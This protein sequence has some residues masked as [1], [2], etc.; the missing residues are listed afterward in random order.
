[1]SDSSQRV[2]TPTPYAFIASKHTGVIALSIEK[3]ADKYYFDPYDPYHK[4]AYLSWAYLIRKSVCDELDIETN[5]FDVGYR[6]SPTTKLPE[7][8][9]VERADNGAGYC[10]YLNGKTDRE[11]SKKVFIDS[12]KPGE[13][14]VYANVLMLPDHEQHCSSSCYDC[15]LDYYNQQHHGSLNWRIALDLVALSDNPNAE[16]DFSQPYWNTYIHETLLTSLEKK[17]KGRRLI[18]SSDII[19][20]TNNKKYLLTHPFWKALFHPK[21]IDASTKGLI[22]LNIIDAIVKTR[23]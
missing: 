19:I 23:F 5:E 11:I 1:M 13:K 22:P 16:L 17:L 6:I 20:E 14:G 15:I 7:V 10:N 3:Y 12:L 4:T 8:Y 21:L 2:H 18:Q 9:I